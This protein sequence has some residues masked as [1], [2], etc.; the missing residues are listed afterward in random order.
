MFGQILQT[1]AYDVSVFVVVLIV[2][3]AEVGEQSKPCARAIGMDFA[4]IT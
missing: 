4:G 3:S 1:A 2:A